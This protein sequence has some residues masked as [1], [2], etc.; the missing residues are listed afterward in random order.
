MAAAALFAGDYETANAKRPSN[1]TLEGKI[2]TEL[3][4]RHVMILNEEFA[5][6][7]WGRDELKAMRLINLYRNALGLVP[8][9]ANPKIHAAAREHSQWQAKHR[10]MTHGRPEK[11]FEN[12]RARCKQQG[13]NAGGGE[14]IA[15]GS[16]EQAVWMWR[17]DAGHHR[18]LIS[19]KW[20]AFALGTVGRYTTYNAGS[21]I[22]D[23]GLKSVVR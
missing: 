11:G 6:K 16:G 2:F 22:E 18:N 10:K 19:P 5:K 1:D 14:N 17:A 12:H 8:M 20:R 7:G 4:R 23:P 21:R 3:V 15:G 13:Y 9:R